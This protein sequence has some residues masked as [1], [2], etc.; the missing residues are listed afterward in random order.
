MWIISG[1]E[2]RKRPQSSN[3]DRISDRLAG[4]SL[5]QSA[6]PSMP[7]LQETGSGTLSMDE[8]CPDLEWYL[9]QSRERGAP[10]RCPFAHVGR[11]PRYFYSRSLLGEHGNTP[12][13]EAEDDALMG[14]WKDSDAVPGTAEDEPTVTRSGE[15]TSFFNF[16][17]EVLGDRFGWFARNLAPHSDGIDVAATHDWLSRHGNKKS[18][19]F[20]WAVC[21]PQHYS[22]CPTYSLL[23]NERPKSDQLPLDVGEVEPWWQQH[24]L[25]AWIGIGIAALG[26]VIGFL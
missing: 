22:D 23:D 14:L 21:T 17:P 9:G 13:P 6:A 5:F 25:L 26:L 20:T 10:S 2:E 15:K 19:H 18:P 16:C 12:I 3:S 7:R 11:C 4:S 24:W 8:N 1:S